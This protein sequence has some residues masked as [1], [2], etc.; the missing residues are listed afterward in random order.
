[1][2]MMPAARTLWC[3]IIPAI[4]TPDRRNVNVGLP[5][6]HKPVDVRW[7]KKKFLGMTGFVRG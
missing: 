6:V 2:M 5:A 1:M 3:G 7:M 4:V